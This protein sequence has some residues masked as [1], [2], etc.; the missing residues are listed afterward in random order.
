MYIGE[1]SL[2]S[3]CNYKNIDKVK[4]IPFG[5]PYYIIWN[6]RSLWEYFKRV[7]H[8]AVIKDWVSYRGSLL[9]A[10]SLITIMLMTYGLIV[11]FVAI[12]FHQLKCRCRGTHKKFTSL[13][14]ELELAHFLLISYEMITRYL[15]R[16]SSKMYT[17]SWAMKGNV[18]W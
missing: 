10:N 2:K 6:H 17:K 14:Q 16:N 11:I 5:Q 1:E 8:E 18:G 4:H 15:Y 12:C 7:E 9:S 13:E 3:L